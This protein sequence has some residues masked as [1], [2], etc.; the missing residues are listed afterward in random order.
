MHPA[1]IIDRSAVSKHILT[2][3]SGGPFW[4]PQSAAARPDLIMDGTEFVEYEWEG[5]H[6]HG[7]SEIEEPEAFDFSN[8]EIHE[9]F[10]KWCDFR[11][12]KS[13]ET[14]LALPI[15]EGRI[16]AYRLI[17]SH[18]HDLRPELGIYW[19]HTIERWDNPIAPWGDQ[20]PDAPTL[21][22]EAM[23][24]AEAVDWETSCAA[25]CCWYCGDMESELRLV[26]GKTVTN[27]SAVNTKTYQ[28]VILPHPESAWTT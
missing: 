26:P 28:P 9:P 5:L 25:L 3:L 18:L 2:S 22:I 13:H 21:L 11:V 23:V 6:S 24:P 14:L 1:S 17:Q 20:S 7:F 8:A 19:S 15:T 27:V 10:A 16:K 12:E 4:D